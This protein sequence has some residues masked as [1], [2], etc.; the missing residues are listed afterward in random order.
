[1]AVLYTMFKNNTITFINLSRSSAPY[2]T[3][4]S[5]SHDSYKMKERTVH[6]HAHIVAT[7][8]LQS[9]LNMA[10]KKTSTAPLATLEML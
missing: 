8:T 1:M 6:S 3:F 5:E 2:L 10:L 7:P 4:E 9:P